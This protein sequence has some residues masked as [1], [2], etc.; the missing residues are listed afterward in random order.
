MSGCVLSW[1]TSNTALTSGNYPV[2]YTVTFNDTAATVK[3]ISFNIA[4]TLC[5]CNPN[6][7]DLTSVTY[8]IGD[9]Q[10][11]QVI[12]AS[13]SNSCGYTVE[14]RLEDQKPDWISISGNTIS[15]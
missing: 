11:S 5:L 2:K 6:V 13:D 1:Y 10:A 14:Y 4:L 9:P 12:S 15:W 3:T 7:V 8:R